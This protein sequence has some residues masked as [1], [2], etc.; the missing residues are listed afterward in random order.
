MALAKLPLER[1]N[2]LTLLHEHQHGKL[3]VMRRSLIRTE[4]C[5]A[6]VAEDP[7]GPLTVRCIN[8]H[9]LLSYSCF[10]DSSEILRAY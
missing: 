6:R 2:P 1:K 8:W 4:Q 3:L 9:W 7:S 10:S 5:I